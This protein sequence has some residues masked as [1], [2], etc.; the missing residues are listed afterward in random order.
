MKE[1]TK[2]ELEVLQLISDGL[3]SSE[4]GE[5]LGVSKRTVESR[6]VGVLSKSTFNNIHP[7][8]KWAVK[9]KLIK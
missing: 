7:I 5:K 9:K 4:I 8:I 1:L 2:I 3:T 6:K